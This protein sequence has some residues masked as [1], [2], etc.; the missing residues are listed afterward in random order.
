MLANDEIGNLGRLGNQMFQYAALRG[1][2][3]KHGYDYCLPPR[4]IVATRD[5]NVVNSDTTIFETFKLPEAPKQVT[6]FPRVMESSHGLDQNLWITV[7]ITL[8]FMDIFRQKNTSSI[9]KRI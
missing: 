2:A 4:H 3:A 7:Q 9:L 1:L 8:V 5:I 6:N